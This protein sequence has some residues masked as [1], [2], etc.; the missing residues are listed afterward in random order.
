[1]GVEEF[2]QRLTFFLRHTLKTDGVG[3][4]DEQALPSGLGM[5]P[6]HRMDG[7]INLPAFISGL[8]L[9]GPAFIPIA[10]TRVRVNSAQPGQHV[11]HTVRQC[12]K[13][14]LLVGEHRIT[15][16]LRTFNHVE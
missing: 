15:A 8:H 3:L 16:K 14:M 6:N 13:G 12:V 2:K 10:K 1:M 5:R 4:V 9:E 11:L 7:F